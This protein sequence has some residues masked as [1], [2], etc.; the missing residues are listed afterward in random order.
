MPA[1]GADSCA[2]S[3]WTA[4]R[5]P[6]VGHGARMLSGLDQRRDEASGQAAHLDIVKG[7]GAIGHADSQLLA[8]GAPRNAVDLVAGRD[9]KQPLPSHPVHGDLRVRCGDRDEVHRRAPLHGDNFAA[10]A[11]RKPWLHFKRRR[12]RDRSPP[13]CSSRPEMG[14]G[15]K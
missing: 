4:T 3:R 12:H 1:A 7:D 13:A 5:R 11:L 8:V 15:Q 9:G 6:A 2:S 10:Q 14:D